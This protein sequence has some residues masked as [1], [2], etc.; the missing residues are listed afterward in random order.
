MD[1]VTQAAL[2]AAVA[3]LI[4]GKKCSP[5]VLLAGAALGTLP[6]LDVLIHYGDPVSD[7]VKHR[8][9]AILSLCCCLSHGCWHWFGSGLSPQYFLSC[10]YG[11][12]LPLV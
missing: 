12:W 9:L 5:K 10:I 3:G 4:A 1:S 11:S 2:G 7:M 6:D 8:A